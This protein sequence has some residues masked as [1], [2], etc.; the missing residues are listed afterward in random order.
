M[1][2]YVATTNCL[3]IS[4]AAVSVGVILLTPIAGA[5]LATPLMTSSHHLQLS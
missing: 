1:T 2:H 5:M 4:L 3:S